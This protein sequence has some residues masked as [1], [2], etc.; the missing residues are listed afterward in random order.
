[1]KLSRYPLLL[2]V[3][4]SW[5]LVACGGSSSSPPPTPPAA[6]SGV[7]AVAK[8]GYVLVDATIESGA[9]GANVYYGTTAIAWTGGSSA[10]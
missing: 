5:L 2:S 6:P 1:M 8:D 3:L 4:T 9:T 10:P 7:S